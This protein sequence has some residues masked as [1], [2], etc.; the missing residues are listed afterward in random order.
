MN[1]KI[2]QRFPKDF[3][4]TVFDSYA[5]IRTPWEK[6]INY[7]DAM[8]YLNRYIHVVAAAIHQGY[9]ILVPDYIERTQAMAENV[10][11]AYL[12]FMSSDMGECVME[13]LNIHPFMKG[14]FCGALM[15]DRA[16]DALLMQGRVNDFGTYRVEKELDACPWDIVGSELCR[17]TTQSLQAIADGFANRRRPGP[18][19]DYQMVEA[20]GCGDLHCR[21]VAENREKY[22]IQPHERWDCMGPVATADQIKFTEEKDC[23]KD[24]PYF[25][26][27]QGFKYTS[28]TCTEL[29]ESYVFEAT[30]ASDAAATF[31]LPAIDY[32]VQQ[33]KVDREFADH[34]LRCVCEASGKAFFGEPYYKEA[35]RDFL[36]V[37]REIGQDGRIIGGHIEVFLQSTKTPYEVEAFNS[38]EAIYQIDRDSFLNGSDQFQMAMITFWYGGT[39]T[40][41]N[42]QWSLWEEKTDDT[43]EDILRIKIAKKIDKF[44]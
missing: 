20:K 23:L 10:Y 27:E 19:M 8:H 40:L 17:A 14:A 6:L 16:D 35:V 15:G 33:G 12:P 30:M 7:H 24:A 37:P 2:D 25:S 34:V 44:C 3:G 38:E 22:P 4:K 13:E 11:Q 9:R 43:P 18:T 41:L 5:A 21:I 26:E 28:G 36:G 32:I 42:A 31:I 1:K 39:K 29:D